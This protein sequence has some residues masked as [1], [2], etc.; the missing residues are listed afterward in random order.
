MSEN[1][2]RI[3]W[4]IRSMLKTTMPIL[5]GM[6]VL[7]IL[8]G[9]ILESFATKLFEFPTIFVLI[10]ALIGI[11]GN[12]GAIFGS[13]L[14]TGIHLGILEFRLDN[15]MFRNN[16]LAISIASLF[17][18]LVLGFVGYIITNAVGIGMLPLGTVIVLSILSGLIL[19]ASL[20]PTSIIVAYISYRKGVDPDDTII[21]VVTSIGDIIG[22]MALFIVIVLLL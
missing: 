14:S 1:S 8:A 16:L 20:I 6:A 19:I 11:G 18:F 21:P 17:I 3:Y 22:L 4:S 12:I 10:P 15:L 5:L 9:I 7:G 2:D 13:R